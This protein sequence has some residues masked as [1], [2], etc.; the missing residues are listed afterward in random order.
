VTFSFEP[1]TA[2]SNGDW[3]GGADYFAFG[4]EFQTHMEG[5]GTAKIYGVDCI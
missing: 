2:E 1:T 3:N 4:H 5:A